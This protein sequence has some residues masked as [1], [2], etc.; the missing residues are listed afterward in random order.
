MK[1]LCLFCGRTPE[2]KNKEHIIPKLLM[3]LTDTENIKMSVGTVQQ[4]VLI[5]Y[6]SFILEL[7]LSQKE[8]EFRAPSLKLQ[9]KQ[10]TRLIFIMQ[11]KHYIII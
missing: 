4:S 7:D 9:A 6:Q 5:D 10:G 3:K 8:L 1:K 2:K 11:A